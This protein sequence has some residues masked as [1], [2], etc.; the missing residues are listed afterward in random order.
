MF[1][2]D[3]V[4]KWRDVRLPSEILA[5]VCERFSYPT[6]NYS[7]AGQVSIGARTFTLPKSA[8]DGTEG[9]RKEP[10]PAAQSLTESVDAEPITTSKRSLISG[11]V[12]AVKSSFK[13]SGKGKMS[14]EEAKRLRIRRYL[15]P[16]KERL[17]V[18]ALRGLDAAA[19]VPEH[20]ETRPLFNPMRP[21]VEQVRE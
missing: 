14:D 10:S 13:L 2:R 9:R 15:G 17:A 3:G 16:E 8:V 20:V 21:G 4:N 5:A 7:V 11:A 6:P 18:S 12:N 1:F 19:L